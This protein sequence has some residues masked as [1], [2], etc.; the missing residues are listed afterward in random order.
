M[1]IKNKII[2]LI[3]CYLTFFSLCSILN[4]DEFNISAIEVSI[5]TS[6]NTVTGKG[7]VVVTDNEGRIIYAD[8]ATYE[9]SKEF[10]TAEG[11]VKITDVDGNILITE[12]VTYNK[13]K[14]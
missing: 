13:T 11:S 14:E 9:K 10:L 7:A 1:Q 4:A 6:N 3:I 5:N 12:K 2:K 8:T